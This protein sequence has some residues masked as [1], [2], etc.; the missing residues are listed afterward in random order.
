MLLAGQLL[1]LHLAKLHACRRQLL[2]PLLEILGG[3]GLGNSLFFHL[4]LPR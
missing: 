1:F 4:L 2:A 3:L